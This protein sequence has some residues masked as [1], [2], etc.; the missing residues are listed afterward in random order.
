MIYKKI[1]AIC[2]VTIMV[3]T[4][5]CA[6]PSAVESVTEVDATVVETIAEVSE[7]TS[8]TPEANETTETMLEQDAVTIDLQEVK[9]NE[10]GQIMVIMYHGLGEK[11]GDYVRTPDGFR[12]DLEML[13]ER[14]YR[15]ISMQD[16]ISN[17]V[18][19]AA[20]L[21][22]FVLTFDDGGQSNFNILDETTKEIDPNCSLG[23]LLDFNKRYPDF[24][25]KGI[26]YLNGGVPFGQQRLLEYKLN[27]LLE[28]GFEI[29]NHS[30]GHEN[31]KSLSAD[32]IM[33]SLGKNE[34]A[35]LS[36]VPDAKIRSISLPFGVRPRNEEDHGVL[37]S[38]QFG[39]VTYAYNSVVNVG[40]RPEY[41]AVHVK[42]DAS[43]IDRVNSGDDEFELAYWVTYF[44]ENP[45]SRY[46][47]DGDPG[48]VTIREGD[49]EKVDLDALGGL[50][51]RTYAVEES[52]QP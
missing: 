21:T 44:D 12:A 47:S 18:D 17:R 30:Y 33:E 16:Y 25:L 15:P 48:I 9:T 43:S 28:H 7:E 42:F 4:V 5:G 23:I 50:E 45:G 31:F 29:G 1:S 20:G 11:D 38:G 24:E 14:G 35:I 27:Y 39:D 2:M 3:L 32:K 10:L 34:Q 46:V 19:L 40:W 22:P 13:Y 52:S 8:E 36:V 26:F 37:M 49:L 41:P 6:S 51:I